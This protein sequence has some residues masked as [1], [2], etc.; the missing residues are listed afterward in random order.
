MIINNQKSQIVKK[1]KKNVLFQRTG[2]V[3]VISF[4]AIVRT[5]P[6]NFDLIHMS[7]VTTAA[8]MSTRWHVD[9]LCALQIIKRRKVM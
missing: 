3:R 4:S 9:V 1:K 8:V 2:Q 5:S 7:D 6:K